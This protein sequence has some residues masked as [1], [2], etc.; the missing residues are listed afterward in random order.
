MRE[1]PRPRGMFSPKLS[2]L[3]RVC[4][5]AHA[6]CPGLPHTHM[7]TFIPPQPSPI[8]LFVWVLVGSP[9]THARATG[10]HV[11]MNRVPAVGALDELGAPARQQQRCGSTV[12]AA[13]RVVQRGP[14]G[15]VF[16]VDIPVGIF[17]GV[18]GQ[19]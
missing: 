17:Q 18:R 4:P 3:P 11:A 19:V 8:P 14:S 2:P 5:P 12:S 9:S 10:R 1:A 13:H 7:Q 6:P 16:K 15:L